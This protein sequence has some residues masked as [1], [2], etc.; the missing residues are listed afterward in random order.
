MSVNSTRPH[1]ATS[2][3]MATFTEPEAWQTFVSFEFFFLSSCLY[4]SDRLLF[5]NDVYHICC[6]KKHWCLARNEWTT[7]FQIWHGTKKCFP[8]L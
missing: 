8:A 3:K 2:Q 5:C 7:I 6:L 1:G 4:Y